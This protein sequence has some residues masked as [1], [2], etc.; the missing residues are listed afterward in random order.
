MVDATVKETIFYELSKI[1][2]KYTLEIN[3]RETSR[4]VR[5]GMAAAALGSSSASVPG[6]LPTGR[7]G[8]PGGPYLAGLCLPQAPAESSPTPMGYTRSF[9]DKQSPSHKMRLKKL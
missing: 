8:L 6:R 4:S 2:P 5:G 3:Q 1:F 7:R 9:S